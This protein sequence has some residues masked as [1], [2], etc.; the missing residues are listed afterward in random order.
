ME[1]LNQIIRM[2]ELIVKTLKS[3][4]GDESLKE[5]FELALATKEAAILAGCSSSTKYDLLVDNIGRL[6]EKLGIPE[7]TQNI[8]SR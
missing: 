7:E 2:N 6:R 4:S 3:N 8:N 5:V 1:D